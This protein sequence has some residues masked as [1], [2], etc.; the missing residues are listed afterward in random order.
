MGT[1]SRGE[2][3]FVCVRLTRPALPCSRNTQRCKST[4]P[5]VKSL[6]TSKQSLCRAGPVSTPSV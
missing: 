3:M 6:K 2:R 4:L 5:Q 1:E